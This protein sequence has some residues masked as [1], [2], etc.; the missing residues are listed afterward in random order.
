ML[1]ENGLCLV[2]LV[3]AGIVV[4]ERCVPCIVLNLTVLTKIN[5]RVFSLFSLCCRAWTLKRLL[6]NPLKAP[7]LMGRPALLKSG[8]VCASG[9]GSERGGGCEEVTLGAVL[10]YFFLLK[11]EPEVLLPVAKP[12]Q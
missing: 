10:C 11:R 2:W 3:F 5:E 9:G 4:I 1:A 12:K 6:Q 8:G 7:A